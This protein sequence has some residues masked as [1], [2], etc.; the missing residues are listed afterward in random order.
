LQ[1]IDQDHEKSDFGSVRNWV[2][3]GL[4]HGFGQMGIVPAAALGQVGL[5]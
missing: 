3:A 2:G 5:V 4:K 1:P